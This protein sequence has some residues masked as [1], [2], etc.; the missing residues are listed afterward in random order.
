MR[1]P[2]LASAIVLLT[3]AAPASA[4]PE[5]QPDPALLER[6]RAAAGEI[7]GFD[8]RFEAEVWLTDMATRLAS[9]IPDEDQRIELLKTVHSE[10]RRAGVP[11]ELVLAIIDVESDFQR[12]AVSH[13]G[14][15]GYMQVMPFW[16][17]RIGRPEADLFDVQTNLRF[18]CTILRYYLVQSAGDLVQALA[19]YNGS[20]GEA[21]YPRR[22]IDRLHNR[23]YRQ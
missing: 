8:N 20:H 11:P 2:G 16:L 4:A 1:T 12:Y 23:W 6:L 9:E 18:G 15:R 21:W 19:R 22:V 3:L 5:R 7:E 13:A 10:A 14:A 17:D